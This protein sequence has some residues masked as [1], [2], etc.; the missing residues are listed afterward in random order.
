MPAPA[1]IL[2]VARSSAIVEML[3]D[4]QV[5]LERIRE[6]VGNLQRLS[7]KADEDRT[8]LDVRKVI[9]TVHRHRWTQIRHRARLI[10]DFGDVP[11]IRETPRRWDRSS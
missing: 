11:Q 4:C 6:T 9:E 8:L 5:G 3:E 10:R 2:P 7:R 1:A